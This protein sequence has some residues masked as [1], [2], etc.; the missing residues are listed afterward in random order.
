MTP[1]TVQDEQE[2]P[3]GLQSRRL[4]EEGDEMLH[5]HHAQRSNVDH[6]GKD[7]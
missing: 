5:H 4:F 1:D 2:P 7:A 3:E 6:I